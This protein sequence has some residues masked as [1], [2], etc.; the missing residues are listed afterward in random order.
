[1]KS[2]PALLLQPP[3]LENWT[4]D[5]LKTP[6]NAILTAPTS[7]SI[8][9]PLMNDQFFI[10]LLFELWVSPVLFSSCCALLAVP[11]AAGKTETHGGLLTCH[12]PLVCLYWPVAC[13][14]V[15]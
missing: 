11:T 14:Y 13:F 3:Q 4:G 1:M 9:S 5:M 6:T 10:F 15:L 7:R 12:F 8:D 2:G